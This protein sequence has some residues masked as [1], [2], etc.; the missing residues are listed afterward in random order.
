MTTEHFK[1]YQESMRKMYEKGKKDKADEIL[2]F[3]NN[4]R[5]NGNLDCDVTGVSMGNNKGQHRGFSASLCL[6]KL[7]KYLERK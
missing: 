5:D 6:S 4:E 1:S 7:I 3:I 2:I